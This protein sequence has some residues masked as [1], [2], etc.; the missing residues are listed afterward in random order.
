MS[1]WKEKSRELNERLK[2]YLHIDH[3]I[4]DFASFCE[5]LKKR[6]KKTNNI[7]SVDY[8]RW[9]E[10]IMIKQAKKIFI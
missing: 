3:F 2:I 4:N 8:Y 1:E 10:K 7:N 9:K 6:K 5:V